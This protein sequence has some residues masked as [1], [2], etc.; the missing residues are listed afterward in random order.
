MTGLTVEEGTN[1]KTFKEK[2]KINGNGAHSVA[3]DIIIRPYK[4]GDRSDIRRIC[5]DTGFLGNPVET[6]FNDREIFADLFTAPYLDREPH[7][8]WVAENNGKIVGYLLGSVS[9]TFHRTLMLSG[10]QTT[11]KMI[12]RAAI[13]R[14]ANHPRSK[15]FIRW[16]LTNGY[17]EQPK[18]PDNAAHLH[19][20]I[21][22]N[23]RGLGLGWRLW[24]VYETQLRRAGVERC[25]GSFFSWPKRRPESVYSR[26]GFSI[27][28]RKQTTIFRPE[29][30]ETVEV[31]CVHKNLGA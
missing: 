24:H 12:G 23:H 15:H 8:A 31:V 14:Y 7:W 25:Y 26:F 22:K 27:F 1:G 6:I 30:S 13:G 19:F 11:M 21:E 29:I 17:W 16:L 5:C 18:Y 9:P 28:D 4:T 2:S 10:F 3:D 20:D